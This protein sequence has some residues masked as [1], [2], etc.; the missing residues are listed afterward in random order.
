M[1]VDICEHVH[2]LAQAAF[3]NEGCANCIAGRHL[4]KPG[5]FLPKLPKLGRSRVEF[6]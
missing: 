6:G 2:H 1:L 3:R 5:Q 4:L